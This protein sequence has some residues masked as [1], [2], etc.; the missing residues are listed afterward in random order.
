MSV[1]CQGAPGALSR[2]ACL[3]FLPQHE[4]APLPAF[5]DVIR[6]V[7]TGGVDVAKL[8]L[9]NNNEA[10]KTGAKDLIASSDL[11]IVA[12]HVLPI[13]MH[14]LALPNATLDGIHT[15]V[16]HPIGL[17]Q[18]VRAM[19]R[20]GIATEEAAN[21]AV[22]AKALDRRDRRVLASAAAAKLYGLAV[23]ARDVQDRPD[24]A[25]IVSI[26]ARSER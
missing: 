18:C 3:C 23:L 20:P 19:A 21:S 11:R 17:R 22:T 6:A 14:L 25:T 9:S 13:R 26:L 10:R 2:K 12:E 8:P 1:A 7:E 16:S 5:G 24:N 4:A 15:V